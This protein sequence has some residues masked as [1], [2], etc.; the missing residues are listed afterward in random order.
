MREVRLM[1]HVTKKALLLLIFAVLFVTACG[2]KQETG[3]REHRHLTHAPNGDLQET[4]D[5]VDELPSFLERQP[6][7]V[8][9]VY[10]AAGASADLLQWIPCYC[11]C[12]ESAGH[13]SSLHCFVHRINE[14]GSVVWDDHGTRCGVC[15]D[16]AAQSIKMRQEGRSVKEIRS[17]ID[18]QYG[19]GYAAP[20]D[21]PLPS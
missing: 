11:G 19:K 18:R 14:D 3:N 12:G 9:I 10:A 20:T 16:I 6:E 15:L 13:R 8:R 7:A 2:A 17:E 1:S 5:S 4:T 21:T